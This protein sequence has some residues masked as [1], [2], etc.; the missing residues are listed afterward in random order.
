[1]SNKLSGS[2]LTQKMLEH[3][4]EKLWCA[5]SNDSDEH[6]ITAINNSERSFLEYIV[7]SNNGHFLCEDGTTWQ[8]AVPVEK[9][10]MTKEEAGF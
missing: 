6:A 9:V 5:V 2:S 8:Y 4:H 3:G 1:M 10:E 7:F